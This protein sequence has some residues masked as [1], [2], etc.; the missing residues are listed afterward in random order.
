L[1]QNAAG[2]Q[3]KMAEELHRGFPLDEATYEAIINAES[4]APCATARETW[5]A[6]DHN[7]GGW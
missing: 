7:V 4:P 5:S 3:D 2:E 1:H 6:S